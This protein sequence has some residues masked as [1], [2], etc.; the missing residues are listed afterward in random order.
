MI[1]LFRLD[2]STSV[3]IILLNKKHK[4]NTEIILSIITILVTA[5]GLLFVIKQIA[6]SRRF[7]KAEFVNQLDL[8]IEGIY[9]T[10]LDLLPGKELSEIKND[11]SINDDKLIGIL[12]YLGFFEK[13]K[14]II[15]NRTI[16]MLTI[17]RLFAFR[18]FLICNHKTIQEQILYNEAYDGYFNSIFALHL[19]WI[20]Y[21]N[22][23]NLDIP[24][25]D[26]DLRKVN[27][28]KFEK[29]VKTY[30]KRF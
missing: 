16:D 30:N 9:E 1:K 6:D 3:I 7:T 15:D 21:R 8:D 11:D 19:D 22:K 2:K 5:I 10:Y 27:P 13:I 26:N 17:D 4:M 20:N 29:F 12:K 25:I 28:I 24:F 23:H 14:L 18:F